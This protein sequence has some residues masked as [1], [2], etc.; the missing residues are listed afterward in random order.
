MHSPPT[1]A[2]PS[3][4]AR[5]P[6][7][8]L[9]PVSTPDA[10][11]LVISIDDGAVIDDP[12][13]AFDEFYS[14]SRAELARALSLALGDVDLGVEAVDEAMARAYERWPT[15]ARLDRPE[16]WVYRVAM[17]WA[18]SFL[19]RRRRSDHRLY[20]PGADHI[21]ISD[22]DVH[23]A[24]GALDVKH[25]TVIVCRHLLGWSVAETAA[26]LKLREGTV[27][28]RLH[29]AHRILQSSLRHLH[30]PEELT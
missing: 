20:D 27:K 25:R 13:P 22:P 16:G 8:P 4:R 5:P 2:A 7:P 3:L 21:A 24:L 18:L 11:P 6:R 30:D 28:S 14:R 15:V 29:R 9:R 19:R 17:N 10:P 1:A 23:A 26:S 12:L